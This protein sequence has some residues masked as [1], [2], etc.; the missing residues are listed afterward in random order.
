[1][2]A[3]HGVRVRSAATAAVAAL[4]SSANVR[5]PCARRTLMRVVILNVSVWMDMV[6]ATVGPNWCHEGAKVGATTV[7]VALVHVCE[8]RAVPVWKVFC[9][10]LLVESRPKPR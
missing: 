9:Y 8:Q 6:G 10:L 5:H 7:H 1:M 2:G 4:S 3:K